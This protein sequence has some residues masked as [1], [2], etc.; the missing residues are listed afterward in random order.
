MLQLQH[1][2]AAAKQMGCSDAYAQFITHVSESHV[3]FGT[4][5]AP[6]L[7]Y[8]FNPLDYESRLRLRWI[9]KDIPRADAVWIGHL[10]GQLSPEQIRDA[11]RAARYS[12]VTCEQ[13]SEELR[14]RI[15]ELNAL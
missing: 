5:S 7:P 2:L 13:F 6:S 11:F 9:G 3:S 4:P 15:K 14:Q 8:V 12:D 10:L 1:A